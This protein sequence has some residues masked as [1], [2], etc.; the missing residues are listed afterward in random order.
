VVARALERGLWV[1]AYA[2]LGGPRRA[3]ALAHDAEL[4]RAAARLGAT[5]AQLVLSGLLALHP[6]IVALPGARRPE[7]A[8]GAA[9]AA[10]VAL[11]A[12]A[13][14]LLQARL[15]SLQPPRSPARSDGEVL[16]VAGLSGAGKSTYAARLGGYVRLNRDLR[17]GTLAGIAAAL[18]EQLGAGAR[19]VVLDNTYLTRASRHAVLRVAARHRVRA[20][21]L[22]LDVPLV[23][24]QRNAVER[25]L[26]AHGRLLAPDELRGDDPTRLPPRALLSQARRLELP[27]EDEGFAAVEVVV[28]VRRAPSGEH[29]G[30]AVALEALAR[31]GPTILDEGEPGP[32]LVF[33]WLP[34][35]DAHSAIADA[36]QARNGPLAAATAGLD[37]EHAAC[38]HPGGPPICWCRPPLPGLLLAFAHRRRVDPGRLTVVGVSAAHRQLAAAV[39][40]RF[41]QK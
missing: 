26:E 3:S 16:L 32:R 28:F 14:E 25:M 4:A 23:E 17:G 10:H 12:E 27:D 20:R 34:D 29:A 41:E 21:C 18:D 36:P 30:R 11:D 15:G 40:A 13:R 9:E 6:R 38:T 35:G 1:L 2:P 39:G 5:P 22:W 7:T 33:A 31:A 8:R 24:A 37:V 19:R